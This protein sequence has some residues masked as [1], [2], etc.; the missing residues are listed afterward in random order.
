MHTPRGAT[1]GVLVVRARAVL[2]EQLHD[3]EVAALRRQEQR[4]T[5]VATCR[6]AL[7]GF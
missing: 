5:P 7:S 2:E 4:R 1:L 6:D 3:I